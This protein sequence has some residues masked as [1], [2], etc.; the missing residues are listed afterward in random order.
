MDAAATNPQH[1]P[2]LVW[3]IYLLH[4]VLLAVVLAWYLLTILEGVPA[5]EEIASRLSSLRW[6]THI[7]TPVVFACCYLGAHHL[8]F[9][10]PK[11]VAIYLSGPALYLAEHVGALFGI[12]IY[13]EGCPGF[14]FLGPILVNLLGFAFA[15]V[16]I[17]VAL[18]AWPPRATPNSAPHC[19]GR[20]ASHG[21]QSSS[22]PARGRGR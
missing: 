1:R 3:G 19:D 14:A 5:V 20:E 21:G 7:G 6:S 10:K 16:L 9:R 17:M 11:A 2:A 4:C 8:F 12:C 15:V 13:P 18:T 22:A